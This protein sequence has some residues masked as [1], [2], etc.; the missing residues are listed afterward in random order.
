MATT[1]RHVDVRSRINADVPPIAMD[2]ER[3]RQVFENVVDN[4]LQHSPRGTAVT[5]SGNTRLHA[6]RECVEIRVEDQGKGF[7]PGE[8]PHVFEPFFTRRER[9]TGLG[10]S[11]VQKI[12]EEHEGIVMA[13]NR[14]EG[15]AR[16]TIRL[17]VA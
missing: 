7:L 9:G 10:L 16:I 12:V 1:T 5:I 13:S 6:G 11:I 15:G 2:R 3:L 4:A 8:T 17:P 14:H